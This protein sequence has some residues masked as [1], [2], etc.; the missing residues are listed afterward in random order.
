MAPVAISMVTTSAT[1]IPALL[2]LTVYKV[3]TVV[4]L[5]DPFKGHG[6]DFG[7]NYLSDFND[8]NASVT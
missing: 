4:N 6:H 5:L 3:S 8:Y 7:K 1:V 2:V